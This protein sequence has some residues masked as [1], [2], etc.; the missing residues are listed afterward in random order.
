[1]AFF[2]RSTSIALGAV[3]LCSISYAQT[4]ISARSG[5]VHYSEGDVSIAGQPV[6]SKFGHFSDV[7]EGQI[8]KTTEGR[9]EVLLTPGVFLRV[10][11][12]SSIKM[13]SSRLI[14][15]RVELV[16]G[17]ILVECAELQKDN[18]VTL[19]YKDA[20]IELHK[21]GLVRIDSAD[22]MIRVYNGEVLV[23]KAGQSLTLKE[24]KETLVSGVL[25][26]EKF[27]NK[28]GDTFYRWASR[29]AGALAVANISAAKSLRDNGT[30]WSSNGWLWNPMFGSYTFIPYRGL[31][32]SPF[33]Y[34]YYSPGY[35]TRVYEVRVPPSTSGSG[36][37]GTNQSPQYNPNLGYDT[38]SRGTGSYQ[39]SAP[40]YSGPSTA[41]TSSA[42]A[43]TGDAGGS[44]NAGGGR[45][46]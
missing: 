6:D 44:H 32:S 34:D 7:K 10:A 23:T 22:D 29:R 1:M 42:P 3:V 9:A 8:L 41:A 28:V 12:D 31:Y 25:S 21:K 20:T 17:S 4:A 2:L 15:T 30:T 13:I 37:G 11:E 14:D 45:G 39:T 33:G 26:P 40:S 43:H 24:G 38:A 16:S 36:F 46:K 5:M 27:D 19:I 18:A 35:V